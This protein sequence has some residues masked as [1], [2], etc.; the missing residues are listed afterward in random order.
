MPTDKCV[1]LELHVC[2]CLGF[3]FVG[4]IRC[5]VNKMITFYNIDYKDKY[6]CKHVA[7]M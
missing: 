6:I 7:Y 2:E 5:Y 3:T 1:L 4:G